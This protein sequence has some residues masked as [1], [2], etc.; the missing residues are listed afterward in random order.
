MFFLLHTLNVLRWET[1]SLQV[2]N[3]CLQ[4]TVN[5][6]CVRLQGAASKL[7]EQQI[8]AD[9]QEWVL[10]KEN[11]DSSYFLNHTSLFPYLTSWHLLKM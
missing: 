2:A 3:Y 6:A 10:L 7:Q 11:M 8:E 5:A 1:T 9:D 4:D